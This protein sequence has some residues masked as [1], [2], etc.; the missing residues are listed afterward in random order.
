MK[1]KRFNRFI[2]E[3]FNRKEAS[4]LRDVGLAPTQWHVTLIIDSFAARSAT[5]KRLRESFE[6]WI[7]SEFSKGA[8]QIKPK[9]IRLD[10]WVCDDDRLYEMPLIKF[11][12][13]SESERV[14]EVEAWV[15]A[16]LLGHVFDDIYSLKKMREYERQS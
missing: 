11:V 14:D 8:W 15:R 9:T 12:L 6:N 4:R 3:S 5:P 2:H 7:A 1:I 16:R 13:E 10:D